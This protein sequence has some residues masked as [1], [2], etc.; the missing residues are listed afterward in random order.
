MVENY[1]ADGPYQ[2]EEYPLI[3]LFAPG[4]GPAR[5]P[6]RVDL[7]PGPVAAVDRRLRRARRQPRDQLLPPA[8][9]RPPT[10][11]ASRSSRRRTDE[12]GAPAAPTVGPARAALLRRP[13][14]GRRAAPLHRA[15][16]RQPKPA[17]PWA[18]RAVVPGRRRRG[19]R[20]RRRCARPTR[21]SRSLQT[22]THYLP[23]G[24][25]AEAAASARAPPPRTAP[26]SRSPPTSTR[27]S[28]P[29]YQPR[30]RRG[31]GRRRADRRR[32][33]GEPYLYR[34]GADVDQ[35][36]SSASST[37]S[38]RPGA[39]RVRARCST[40]RSATATT[41]GWRTSASTRRSTR[42]PPAAIAGHP[43][44]QPLLRPATTAPPTRPTAA[45]A[46][47]I[48]RFQRSG[49]TGV[50]AL[51]AGRLGRRPDHELGLRRPA[52]G[53]HPGALGRQLGHRDL[54]LGH[55]R[56]LRPRREP[57]TPELLTRWVQLGA[58][59]PVMRTQANG[60]AVPPKRPAA[61]DRPR[62]A[63]QLAPLHQAAHAALSLPRRGARGRTGAPGMP[64]DA[65]PRR[66]S[67]RASAR[68]RR[69]RTSSCSAPTCSRR[70]CSMPGATQ[71]TAL[72]AA[73][74]LDRPLALGLLPIGR[75]RPRTGRRRG[76]RGR[77]EV[78]VPA[79]LDELPLLVRAGAVV[80]L[81]PPRVDTL[82]GYG[83]G[84][85]GLDT[86]CES[87]R[88]LRLLAFPRGRS[89]AHFNRAEH[90]RSTEGRGEWRSRST[91]SGGAPTAFRRRWR[92]C[93]ARSSRA[94][95]SSTGASWS[96]RWSYDRRSRV[97][98]VSF[99]GRDPALTAIA[100]G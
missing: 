13:E 94:R 60:V 15:T 34:Y 98:R 89:H 100:C 99:Q 35:A 46:R 4:L 75:R 52:L 44:A 20:D 48:V 95:S 63:R 72:P 62:P 51:R 12:P 55:R 70:R 82:A 92:P 28:A 54:G 80:P 97:L 27:W 24:D 77:R 36:S 1:V 71:R 5:R 31:R 39:Q 65:P 16:G 68:R 78:T 45:A 2:A 66:S 18:A 58:V 32:G 30:L 53:G 37:S 43:R 33:S 76:L 90:L 73:R 91:A 96:R 42:S 25:Q 6:P 59:S 86:L 3:N 61:G 41:A 9:R 11:G 26:A 67:T 21:R 10:P 19:G 29:D 22:Y 57:L 79:P 8:H 87:R 85:R 17:A 7:L 74:P 64:R 47:P 49:W 69:A 56:L 88:R 81:L 14:A 50:R 38:P 84:V 83:K 40:R 23:C 93:A